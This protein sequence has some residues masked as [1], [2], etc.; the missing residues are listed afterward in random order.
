MNGTMKPM[1]EY[2]KTGS[3]TGEAGTETNPYAVED[4]YDFCAIK[5]GADKEH[6]K[7]MLVRDIDFNNH[8]T[9][10]MATYTTN[11]IVANSS[12]VDGNGH[13]IR[14]LYINQFAWSGILQSAFG[15]AE[16]TNCRF[17]NLINA[18]PSNGNGNGIFIS[19]VF[20]HCSFYIQLNS[21]SLSVL[22]GKCKF[23]DCS[24]N[25]AGIN[26]D[27]GVCVT[28]TLERCHI[29]FKDLTVNAVAENSTVSRIFNG[30]NINMSYFT[31]SVKIG[32][33]LVRENNYLFRNGITLN[34]SYFCA[35]VTS[36]IGHNK[37][38][39]FESVP[40]TVCFANTSLL[41]EW[42]V[43]GNAKFYALT[44][45]QCKATEYLIS[46]IGFPVIGV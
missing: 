1:S 6:S 15:L 33:G 3:W 31:G 26:S 29:N 45:E 19:C 9:Y 41:A 12:S 27:N 5:D 18:V 38:I 10:K 4:V 23:S 20:R 32:G 17:E 46:E 40:S 34:S 43:V 35:S 8:E 7:Y 22:F 44:D 21:A 37:L 30:M 42:N 36:S 28:S 14:N 2:D 25:I 24:V 13:A 39:L 11:I 16:I